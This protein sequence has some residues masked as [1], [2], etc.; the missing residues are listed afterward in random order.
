MAVISGKMI[1]NPPCHGG[2]KRVNS[3]AKERL[4]K[5]TK[6]GNL[7]IFVIKNGESN[8]KENFTRILGIAR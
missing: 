2:Y 5:F 7:I 3:N 8:C 6:M 1:V 4:R